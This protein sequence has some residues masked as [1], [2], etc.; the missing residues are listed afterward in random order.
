MALKHAHKLMI[1]YTQQ[2][3][4]LNKHR[5]KGQQ[6]VTV[7]HV[8]VAPGGQAIVGNIETGAS[9]SRSAVSAPKNVTY[10]PAEPLPDIKQSVKERVRRRPPRP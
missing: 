7:E 10:Q 2:L 6:K 8:N 5:G 4:A 1:L 3:A 9:K